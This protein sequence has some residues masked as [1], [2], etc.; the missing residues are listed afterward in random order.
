MR[1]ITLA[2]TAVI[3]GLVA[4]KLMSSSYEEALLSTE[5][6]AQG[7]HAER[8]DHAP[9]AHQHLLAKHGLKAF[10]AT[11]QYPEM[12]PAV[13]ALYESAAYDDESL[14]DT[15]I[16]MNGYERV[17]PVVW[18]FVQNEST[19]L[20]LQENATQCLQRIGESLPSSM[21]EVAKV[22][23]NRLDDTF[24]AL[25]RLLDSTRDAVVGV[26][27]SDCTTWDEI[28]PYDR[29]LLALLA[30]REDP[31]LLHEFVLNG[32]GEVVRLHGKRIIR[33]I[34][35]IFVGGILDVEKKL[36]TGDH[37]DNM[38][39]VLAGSE[40]AVLG[41]GFTKA[42]KL[43]KA[44]KY[45]KA[46]KGAA[47]V[48]KT[49]RRAGL[50][51][52]TALA[53]TLAPT[54]VKVGVLGGVGY[55]ALKHPTL[56]LH[57]IA[58]ALEQALGLPQWFA[59]SIAWGFVAFLALLFVRPMWRVGVVLAHLARRTTRPPPACP[60]PIARADMG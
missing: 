31:S 43:A 6:E 57:G 48:A 45:A 17:V 52:T 29:G 32:E 38:D 33:N 47:K 12:A 37:V 15:V 5:L 55:V 35:T 40:V 18:Y 27:S 58:H 41:Y 49:T 42:A 30:I 39:W 1:I 22:L 53:R 59:K 21:D 34:G 2:L 56:I 19:A 36:T 9:L 46:S 51:R 60:F 54:A 25:G 4:G 16:N 23:P 8:F 24:A 7:L 28:T 44:S 50:A 20:T 11:E 10:L 14:L 3:I 13:Y 26:A